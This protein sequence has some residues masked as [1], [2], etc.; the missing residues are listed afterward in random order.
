VTGDQKIA[1]AASALESIVRQYPTQLG[2]FSAL[3]KEIGADIGGQC[4][5]FMVHGRIVRGD[6]AKIETQLRL[7]KYVTRISLASTGGDVGEAIKI[8]T[9]FRR[10]LLHVQ[11]PTYFSCNEE[12]FARWWP[13]PSSCDEERKG[14]NA[15]Q[16]IANGV[17]ANDCICAS[18]CVI[19]FAG[20]PSRDLLGI[21]FMGIDHK[22]DS[23]AHTPI[24]I[25]R[26][27]ASWF[28]EVDTK[29]VMDSMA[30]IRRTIRDALDSFEVSTQL[31]DLMYRIPSNTT[32]FL[33]LEEWKQFLPDRTPSWDERTLQI[34]RAN[35]WQEE[36]VCGKA[37]QFF[38]SV[39]RRR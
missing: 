6:A 15:A 22:G 13:K 5:E 20:A 9:V 36:E 27:T 30:T 12:E 25:H 7:N 37:L 32:Y 26:P 23:Y 24:G 39:S 19:A 8:G 21:M 29:S 35:D 1:E 14:E 31:L 34:C 18:A 2:T 16:C 33:T 3:A 4:L 38:E 17:P 11:I 10:Y 28:A